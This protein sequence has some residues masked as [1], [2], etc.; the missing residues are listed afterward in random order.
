VDRQVTRIDICQVSSSFK[1][2]AL[3][4]VR[5]ETDTELECS[6]IASSAENN[7]PL[8]P[9]H[10]F[11]IVHAGI[12]ARSGNCI[13]HAT[14][15][16]PATA[17]DQDWCAFAPHLPSPSVSGCSLPVHRDRLAVMS[18]TAPPGQGPGSTMLPPCLFGST[19]R[20][21]TPQ[22]PLA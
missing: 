14:P 3:A 21:P 12:F 2:L 22:N 13:M 5:G 10:S 18:C 9:L 19:G 15:L 4:C 6:C 20:S 16:L 11:S 17:R 7:S 1:G 8:Q